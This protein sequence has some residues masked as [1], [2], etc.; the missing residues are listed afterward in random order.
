MKT[1]VPVGR[2]MAS[3]LGIWTALTSRE[4]LISSCMW[5]LKAS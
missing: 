3:P 2:V 1:A 5:A 4:S